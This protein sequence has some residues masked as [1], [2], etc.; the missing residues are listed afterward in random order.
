MEL[1]Q[2][3]NATMKLT[4]GN[5]TFLIDPWLQDKGT[6]WS[7]VA[8]REE[9]KGLH[10]PLGDLPFSPEDVLN[11]VDYLLV[12]H[13]HPD[14]FSTHYIP[15]EIKIITQ[16]ETDREKISDLGYPNTIT[17]TQNIIRLND[18]TI[19]RTDGIHGEND[20][21]VEKMGK[22]SGFVFQHTDEKTIYF[23]GD[24]VFYQ[25]VEDTI[26]KYHPDVIVLN[27]CEATIPMGIEDVKKVLEC[28]NRETVIV[29]LI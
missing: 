11:E 28:T 29:P 10:C 9:M 23:C 21:V 3:R 7:A 19:T 25:N 8:I 4:Y 26:R 5:E 1:R 12:S 18:I 2:I 6:G 27:C 15:N 20:A 16:D 24:S 22:I 17:F 14:H 13:I